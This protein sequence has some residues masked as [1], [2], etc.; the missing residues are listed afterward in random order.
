MATTDTSRTS[1]AS[2]TSRTAGDT[3]RVAGRVLILAAA[4]GSTTWLLG[5]AAQTVA[6]DRHAS[7][8]VGRASGITAYLLLT[9][10][11]IMGLVLAHPWRTRLRRPSTVTRIR[12]HVALAAF[13]LA[14]TVLHIVVLATDRYAGVGW[15]GALLPLG[16]SYRP[17]PVTLGVIGLYAGLLAGITA[18]A[19]GRLPGR[20]WWLLHKVSALALVLV[21]AHGLFAGSDTGVLR[22]IYV[23]GAV[24][25][26]GL[27]LSRYLATTPADRRRQLAV[28]ASDVRNHPLP[29]PRLRPDTR[30]ATAAT[31]NAVTGTGVQPPMRVPR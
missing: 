6:G 14:F 25:L 17:V 22:W 30:T 10:V 3:G 13:T 12:L 9:L 16:S 11:V 28:A 1:D 7:W 21:W 19:A 4:G 8:I 20:L 31:G 23:A 26:I 24:A 15:R 5:R 2:R 27:A 29:G 18:A